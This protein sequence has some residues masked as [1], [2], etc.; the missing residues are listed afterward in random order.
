MLSA[1]YPI[2]IDNEVMGAV[3]AEET[4]NGIRTLRNRALE[5]LFNII[6]LVMGV[7]TLSLFLF[8][9]SISSRIRKLRDQAEKAIDS[10]GRVKAS[11]QGSKDRDEIGDLSRSFANIV[12]R[13]AQYTH[14]LENMSSRLSH[15]LRTPVAVVRSSLEHLSL[16]THDQDTQKYLDRAQEGVNRLNMILNNMSEATRLEQSIQSNEPEPFELQKIINGCMQG[17]QLTYP[18]HTFKLTICDSP[19]PMMGAPEFIAQLLDKLINN[20]LEFS[21]IDSCI[22]VSLAKHDNEAVLTVTNKGPLLPEGISEHIFDSMVSIRSQQLQQQPHLGLGLYIV[23]LVCDYH[24][25]SVIA[26][27]TP[28]QDGVI[29]TIRLPISM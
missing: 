4:T 17:Y 1:A 14:Y 5:R 18:H 10:Q 26:E 12:G 7:G 6:L 15:E 21:L 16:K 24:D 2:Y 11:L 8:A 25:G 13:L 9:S 23:R 28:Q 3:I 29:F 27:N 19:I 20:A 22:S